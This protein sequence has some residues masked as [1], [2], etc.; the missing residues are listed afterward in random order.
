MDS[1]IVTVQGILENDMLFSHKQHGKKFYC[2]TISIMRQ[3]G[4]VDNIPVI[5]PGYVINQRHNVK[6]KYV[7]IKGNYRSHNR[8][9]EYGQKHLDLFIHATDFYVVDYCCPSNDI[10]LCGHVCSAPK[11][12]QTPFCRNITDFIIATNRKHNK[13]D[14][15]PCICWGRNAKFASH[16]KVGDYVELTGRIQSREYLKCY[17]GYNEI[18]TAYEIS[19]NRIQYV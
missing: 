2:N 18:K 8:T 13:N 3:S 14:Y 4:T 19:V 11:Y 16:L 7:F 1:N 6:G 12:R 10:T 9:D 15:A 5:F 17:N